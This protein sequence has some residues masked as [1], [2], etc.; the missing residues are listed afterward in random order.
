M[1]TTPSQDQLDFHLAQTLA[2]LREHWQEA[3]TGVVAACLLDPAT[4][5]AIYDV[6]RDIGFNLYSHAER[7]V[8]ERYEHEHGAPPPK[9]AVLIT[10]LSPCVGETTWRV[11]ESCSDLAAKYG[12]TRLHT[13]FVD[14][15]HPPHAHAPDHA[16]EITVTK[17]EELARKC[18]TLRGLFNLRAPRRADGSTGRLADAYKSDAIFKSV[19]RP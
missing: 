11:G 14:P 2:Y 19:F 9:D 8:I 10:T 15:Q 3:G 12:L 6:S 13:G 18:E 17:N 7:N 16:F 5:E 4:G 1:V